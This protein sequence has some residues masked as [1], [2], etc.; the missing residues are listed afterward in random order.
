MWT[1]WPR[2]QS[3]SRQDLIRLIFSCGRLLLFCFF[4]KVLRPHS[5]NASKLFL[6]PRWPGCLFF[7][8]TLQSP[9][10]DIRKIIFQPISQ[11]LLSFHFF[12]SDI[13]VNLLQWLFNCLTLEFLTLDYPKIII[14]NLNDP[15]RSHWHMA[16]VITKLPKPLRAIQPLMMASFPTWTLHCG[17]FISIWQQGEFSKPW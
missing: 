9:H 11:V 1:S 14:M 13:S 4:F 3:R 2:L 10:W 16:G 15:Q 8:F 7:P 6:T 12:C 5:F 17:P